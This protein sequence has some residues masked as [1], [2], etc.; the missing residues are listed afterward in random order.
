[1]HDIIKHFVRDHAGVWT[2]IAPT[3]IQAGDDRIRV[4][5]GARFPRG[6]KVKDLEIAELLDNLDRED[7]ARGPH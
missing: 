3:E 6:A 1:M 5:L 7:R 4:D 2:C